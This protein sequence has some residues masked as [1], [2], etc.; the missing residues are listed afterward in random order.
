MSKPIIGCQH[1]KSIAKIILGENN[2]I[3][4]AMGDICDNIYGIANML[5][6]LAAFM[7]RCSIEI[8]YEENSI[9]KI[10]ISDNIT[11][12]FKDI[13]KGG[14]NNPLNMGHIR[15]GQQEDLESSEF[16]TGLKK[17]LIFLARIAEIYTRCV[18]D[19][20]NISFV[21]IKFE[22]V[23]MF[24]VADPSASYEPTR[25]ECISEEAF[26][27]VHPSN[28][29]TGSTIILSELRDNDYTYN[30]RKG[31]HMEI[32]EF[33]DHF[34]NEI[35]KK[36]SGLIRQN[37]IQIDVNQVVVAPQFNLVAEIKCNFPTHMMKY[38][39]YL[40]I[41][42]KFQI[43]DIVRVG[44]TPKGK[45]QIKLLEVAKFKK[46]D[47]STLD[48]LLKK[49]SVLKV[50]MASLTTY[51]TDYSDI[52]FKDVTFISR[53]GRCFGDITLT[54]Q[55]QDGWSN[56]IVHD[57]TYTNKKLNS[58]LGVGSNKLLSKK[59][60]ALMTAI[61]LT[62]KE[63][64]K[65]FRKFRKNGSFD[66]DSDD[67]TSDS[68]ETM[69]VCSTSSTRQKKE[70]KQPQ[71][72]Q[73]KASKKAA[74]LEEISEEEDLNQQQ[75]CILNTATA[76]ETVVI[77]EAVAVETDEKAI[78]VE[79]DEKAVAVKIEPT[80]TITVNE[81]IAILKSLADQP[82]LNP[83]LLDDITVI[84][85]QFLNKCDAEQVLFVLKYVPHD[86]TRIWL[87]IEMIE[88]M[89][90]TE[91]DRIQYF[92]DLDVTRLLSKE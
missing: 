30:E 19:D 76:Q 65:K 86:A 38:E 55:Q 80:T 16:G 54:T 50:D 41:T 31:S 10:K 5:M 81:N 51:K 33:E 68:D 43:R 1:F 15:I 83:E 69:S 85:L 45:K 3:H 39:F 21:Y 34:R 59:S 22:F 71:K 87:L 37:V 26:R 79:T 77:L 89:F 46:C 84:I 2:T 13:H 78:S 36:M 57:I 63:C 73:K 32:T 53:S 66:S 14:T 74:L 67:D 82:L 9:Y 35:S 91:E 8:M 20:G 7:A 24:N 52:Q 70:K 48:A 58:L 62:Q 75:C 64:V 72:K 6:L 23:T 11:H 92:Q 60:N 25:F 42:P 4:S 90:P 17:A 56:H 29:E 88:T 18:D 40:D 47:Q 44:Q 28:F 49:S 61:Q 12:G 27:A